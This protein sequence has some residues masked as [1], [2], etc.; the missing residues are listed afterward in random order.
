MGSRP[1]NAANPGMHTLR[2]QNATHRMHAR[3]RAFSL[4]RIQYKG[5][6][7][8]EVS[9][10][11]QVGHGVGE[12]IWADRPGQPAAR[13]PSAGTPARPPA[14]G[15]PP[16]RPGPT[17]GRTRS[18]R[19]PRLRPCPARPP[20]G[21]PPRSRR[22]RRSRLLCLRRRQGREAVTSAMHWKLPWRAGARCVGAHIVSA[23][24]SCMQL[25][26]QLLGVQRSRKVGGVQG[27]PETSR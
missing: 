10:G 15:R 12:G 17:T 23:A 2:T 9:G 16:P 5:V 26:P 11:V 14:P 24:K 13:T 21:W 25:A 8:A 4:R 7:Q 27:L 19:W 1:T 6:L 18:R 22:R 20:P 3:Q